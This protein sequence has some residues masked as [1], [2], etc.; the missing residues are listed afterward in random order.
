M[1]RHIILSPDAEADI[2][3]IELWYY[4]KEPSLSFKFAAEVQFTSR[5]I[6]QYPRAF[7]LVKNG[8]RRAL[9]T[10]FP[11]SI[12]FTLRSDTISVIAV[13]HQHRRQ[14]P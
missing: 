3:A 1:N 11:Y 12:Y 2:S 5:L 13:L 7:P 10:A 6:A 9:M 8:V 4:L 14:E